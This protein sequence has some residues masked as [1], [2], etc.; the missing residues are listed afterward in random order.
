MRTI[1]FIKNFANGNINNGNNNIIII[2]IIFFGILNMVGLVNKEIIK[3]N[4]KT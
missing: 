2:M 1:I 4:D 3:A